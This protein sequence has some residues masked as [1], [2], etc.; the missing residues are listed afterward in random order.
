MEA[1]RRFS[2]LA[3]VALVDQELAP[4]ERDVLLRSA[5]AL[6]LPQERAAQIVQ[7]LMRGK[8][9]ED[10]TPPESPRERRKLFKEFVAI[11]LA[12]GVVTPAEESCLQRLAPTYGVDPERVPLILER[13]GK[14]PKIALEAP[15]APPRRIQGATNCPSCGAPISFKNAHSVSRV[16][17]YCDTTVVREDGSDVLK[18]LGKISHL[19]ED[20]S[21]IQVGARGTCFGVSFEVLGRLQVEHATGF[22]N[23]WYLEWDDHRTGWLGEALGQYFVTFPAAAMD[24]ET[25]RS[26]PDFDAL[27]VGERLR[28]QSKRYVV[29]EKRVARVTGTEGETPFRVHE[30]YTLPYADL[31]RADDGFATIDYSESPPLVFTGR[32]VGW[33]HLNLRGYREFDGW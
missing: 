2:L 8:Q 23:E 1:E 31:R 29:T 28:L 27:K 15:K 16:C 10:L 11:V 19:G 18:D 32:C 30:G 33:K 7:D 6:G 13:E 20:S 26:L 24:D 17:E 9:L 5:E 14:K 25:R 21:P 22:W 4:A 12:D 3:A